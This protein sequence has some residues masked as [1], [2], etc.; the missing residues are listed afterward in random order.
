MNQIIIFH[1]IQ[2]N[3]FKEKYQTVKQLKLKRLKKPLK[4]KNIKP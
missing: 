1:M 3:N 4:L 2:D